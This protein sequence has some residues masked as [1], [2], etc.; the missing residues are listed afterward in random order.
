LKVKTPGTVVTGVL[1][2]KMPRAISSMLVPASRL[3]I[4]G[5][6]RISIRTEEMGE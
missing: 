2:R 4:M 3:V 6:L 5:S 1:M